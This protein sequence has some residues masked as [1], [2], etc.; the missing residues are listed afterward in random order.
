MLVPADRPDQ[1]PNGDW[2]PIPLA[3]LE[4]Q[5]DTAAIGRR[6][7]RPFIERAEYRATLVHDE[8][9]HA[10]VEWHARRP[11]SLLSLMSA[12][13]MNLNVS[14][15]IWSDTDSKAPMIPAL[16]GTTPEGTTGIVVDRRQGLLVGEWSVTGRQLAASVEFD[17]KLPP[18]TTS[19][20]AL[21]VPAGL[22]L[23][24]TAGEV[25]S[26]AVPAEPGWTEW[27]VKLGSRT[28]VRLRVAPQADAT[29]ARPLVIVRSNLNYVVRS[30]AVRLLAEFAVESLESVLREVHLAVDPDIQITSIENGDGGAVAWRTAEMPDGRKIVAQLPDSPAG[31]VQTL[32]VQG[33]AQIK[34]FAAW[35]LPRIRVQGSVE[36]AGKVT[37]RIQPPL[38][39]ADIRTEGCLQTELTTSAADGET[40]VFKQLRPDGTITIVPSDD[41]PDLACRA[42][43]LVTCESNQWSLMTQME[44]TAAAGSEFSI[45][46]RIPALWEIVDVRPAPGE[47]PAALA[48]WDVE[49]LGSERRLLHVFFSN[50]LEPDRPQRVR[51]SARRL[52]PGPGEQAAMPPLIPSSAG[53][54]EHF[55]VVTTGPEW[56]PVVESTSEI[57]VLTLRD[58]PEDARRIEFLS[59]RLADRHSRFLAFRTL[60]PSASAGLELEPFS[61]GNVFLE[62]LQRDRIYSQISS[63]PDHSR[64]ARIHFV[65]QH[66]RICIARTAGVAGCQAARVGPV[67]R[68]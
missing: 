57:E 27:N 62:E 7:P 25:T 56:R 9:R 66:I 51:I 36:D 26:N 10:R 47:N 15:L 53:E 16:W 22:V 67:I 68:L 29:A 1:W 28:S 39:A 60:R 38:E 33:I 18:A 17:L 46:C 6:R 11:D 41:K 61:Q 5:L 13:E 12:G 23:S 37:L 20:I 58:L 30:E 21:K 32:R 64:R 24:S 31:E 55:V 50:A 45:D 54:V 34:P 52:P 3:E 65:S 63:P 59:S 14:K 40:L 4:R 49:E 42:V 44:W 8:L 19:R 43:S 2:Q 35:T 48:G